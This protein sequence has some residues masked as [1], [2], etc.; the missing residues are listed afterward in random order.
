MI[1]FLLNTEALQINSM[2]RKNLKK[3]EYI[4][5]KLLLVTSTISA[6]RKGSTLCPKLSDCSFIAVA[7]YLGFFQVQSFK[8]LI[9]KGQ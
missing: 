6:Q 3:P 4:Y 5:L 8:I 1:I 2:D 7:S 9:L